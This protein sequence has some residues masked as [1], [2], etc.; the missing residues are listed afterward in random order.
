[1]INGKVN[2]AILYK[3]V[4]IKINLIEKSKAERSR[5]KKIYKT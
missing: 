4:T 3:A 1:M 5:Q 2:S